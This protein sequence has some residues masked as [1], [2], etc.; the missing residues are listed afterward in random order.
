L[1]A[2]VANRP[3][4]VDD[5]EQRHVFVCHSGTSPQPS[6]VQREALGEEDNV[7]DWFLHE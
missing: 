4:A 3:L 7:C 5:I 2:K 6:P 1:F